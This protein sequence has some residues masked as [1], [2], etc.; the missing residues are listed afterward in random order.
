MVIYIEPEYEDIVWKYRDRENTR[1]ITKT[2]DDLRAFPFYDKVQEIRKDPKWLGQSGWLPGST[3]ANLE[4]YNPLVMSK[5]FLLNDASLFNSFDTKYF[6]WVDGGLSNT[7]N[8]EAYFN[9]NFEKLVIPHLN[10]MM[11]VAFPYDGTVEVHGFAKDAMNQYAG[12]NTEY[13]CRGG[14]FGGTK[15]AI[16]SF[17]DKY[18]HLLNETLQAGYMGT[19]ESVFTILTYRDPKKYNLRF[20]EGN[21]LV[22]KFF[23]DLHANKLDTTVD[24]EHQLAFYAITYNL[25]KQFAMLG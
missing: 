3:Q 21:G 9:K 7:V 1:V 13:V 25:P 5:Q 4:L 18:Y 14:L 20:I 19:E 23:E 2:L 15:D 17:N 8:L 16:N 22:Y 6:M 11:F 10:K 24:P 12:K